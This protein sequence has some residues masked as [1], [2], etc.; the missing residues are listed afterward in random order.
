MV[1]GGDEGIF[2]RVGPVPAVWTADPPV[3]GYTDRTEQLAE[4]RQFAD[5]VRAAPAVVAVHARPGMGKT[6]FLRQAAAVLRDR[7]DICLQ[8][9]FAAWHRDGRVDMDGVLGGMLEAL[10]VAQ[11]WIPA[12]PAG[13]HRRYL[14]L[15]EGQRVL[16]LLDNVTEPAQVEYLIPNS[17]HALVLVASHVRLHDLVATHRAELRHLTGLSTR[18]GVELLEVIGVGERVKAEPGETER[19]V[20][21]CGGSP[22]GLQIAAGRLRFQPWLSVAELVAE[23]E[24]EVVSNAGDPARTEGRHEMTKGL[25]S[26]YRAL[27]ADAASLCRRLAVLPGREF[28]ERIIAAAAGIPVRVAR[29][30][31]GVLVAMDLLEQVDGGFRMPDLVRMYAAGA[32]AAED[33]PEELDRCRARVVRAWCA[34]AMAADR[35]VLLDRYRVPDSFEPVAE[36]ETAGLGKKAALRWFGRWHG[37]LLDV[38]RHAEAQQLDTEAWQLFEAMWP[39]YSTHSYLQA[40]LEA[41]ALAVTC[42]HRAGAVAAEARV[43]CLRSRASMNQGDFAAAA[44]DLDEARRLAETVDDGRRL[45]ASVCDFSGQLAY[46]QQ[47]FERALADFAQ[48]LAISEDLGDERGTGLQ[49]Q[50]CGRSLGRLGRYGE[51]LTALDR[52]KLLLERAGDTRALSRTAFSRGEVLLAASR[53]AEAVT[54]LHEA[55]EIA[56]GLEASELVVKPLELLTELARRNGDQAAER[57]YLTAVVELHLAGGSPDAARYQARLQELSEED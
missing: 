33:D 3:P 38:L 4:L 9:D 46:R 23:L 29:P 32:A 44:T 1:T 36:S 54:S 27:D 10:Y 15:L 39:F 26:A 16:V 5:Q 14:S 50:F 41:G 47:D 25:D 22:H 51:A 30:R 11:Q 34:E 21:I 7:F 56:N 42:A 45:L 13:R 52:A 17:A 18:H 24:S 6:A 37:S 19:L 28:P 2:Q 40:W 31:I 49:A 57:G 48:A 20:E 43:R 35:A 8:V 55:V 12:D 53:E